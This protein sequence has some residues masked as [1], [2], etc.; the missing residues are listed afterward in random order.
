MT[1]IKLK[2][3]SGAPDAADL[4]QGEVALDLTNK[5]IYSENASGTV[6]EMGTSP[7]TIDIN[8]GTI[9]GAVIG[10]ASAAAGTFTTLNATGGG[11]LTGT[12]TNLGTVTTVDINGGTIDGTTIG[13]ASAGAITGT[14]ITGTSFVSS[15]DMTFGDDDKAI[16]GAG[17]DLQISHSGTSSRIQ[18]VGTGNLIIDTNGTEIQLT[19]GSISEYML[20]AV[21]DGAV[22]LYYDNAAKLATTNTGIDV[23]GTVTADGLTVDGNIKLDGDG[24][25]LQV[26]KNV[27]GTDNVL[28]YDNTVSTNDLYI[29]R[30]SSNLRLRTGTQN[31][32]LIDSDGDISF[33]EDTG[34]TPKLFWDASA[35]SLGIGTDS[36]QEE[37]HVQGTIV[38]GTTTG[39]GTAM[40][41]NIGLVSYSQSTAVEDIDGLY[42]R[43]SGT[44]GS[45]M[46]I[47]FGNAGGGSY[48]VGARIKHE[49][50]GSNSDGDL[51]F[52]TKGDSSTNT[53]AEAM[54][55]DSSG[56]VGIGTTTPAYPIDV[57]SNSSAQTIRLRGRSSD[58]V[59]NL[60]LTSNDAATTYGVVF[61]FNNQVGI[62]A[63]QASGII[64]FR[65]GGTT[66]RMRLD[67]SG[68]LLV[69]TSSPDAKLV[70]YQTSAAP[71]TSIRGTGNAQG[72]SQKLTIV[73][74]YPVVSLGTKLIIPFISQG[75]LYSTTICKVIGHS[76]R[77]NNSGPLGFEITFALA[78][79]TA[80]YNLQS[81]GGN[82]NFSSIAVNGMNIE[83]T[84][85]TAYTNATGDGVF[86]AIEYMTNFITRSIDVPNIAMN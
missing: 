8:A 2:N 34:T 49:R 85:T 75:N 11:A 4:V 45:S 79:L 77:Y 63:S 78:H 39:Y 24:R 30:D 1:T 69:G 33:Y 84:F 81:W 15:G 51:V 43:K 54:R 80:L 60:S 37:L 9:D 40:S 67:A 38:A 29:G 65:S 64:T 18:D 32:L 7:S 74:H 25:I 68:N 19:S 21:K 31:R 70:A 61:A 20:R 62:E 22:T 3:G 82:G 52:E 17:S 26:D 41:G 27:S 59:S 5:R 48:Y 83:I 13:G 6:I 50:T 36:P 16:F 76:A 58:S 47:A 86:V 12:W 42:L 57:V 23:T 73:R 56:N 44:N 66:E 46:G 71:V 10:G 28:Y 53:T 72:A 14:T 55:I 35:E